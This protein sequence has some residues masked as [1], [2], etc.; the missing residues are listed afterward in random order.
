MFPPVRISGR[1][2][3]DGG[4]VSA[5]S[6][7]LAVEDGA[8]T[9][10]C[11]APL[12]YRNE[13]SVFVPDPHAWAPMLTRSFFARP[14]KREVN[15]ACAKGVEVLVIRPWLE[16]LKELGSNA[17]RHFDRGTVANA[18]REGTLRLLDQQS[19]H[20][21]LQAALSSSAPEAGSDVGHRLGD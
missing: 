16:E 3:V 13:G 11:V 5:T 8:D 17:M 12:G 14:L 15:D 20:P 18:A 1:Q 2:Y 10:I 21:A 9:I 7:D 6:L 19:D 4:A